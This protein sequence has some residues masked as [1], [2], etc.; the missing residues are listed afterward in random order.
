MELRM[1]LRLH[2]RLRL[3]LRLRPHLHLQQGCNGKQD[4]VRTSWPGS[5]SNHT[6]IR[7]VAETVMM[8]L[9]LVAFF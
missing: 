4:M 5:Q 7:E 3:R 1:D 9:S 8:L 2:L 6:G